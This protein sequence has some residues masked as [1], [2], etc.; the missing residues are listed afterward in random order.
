MVSITVFTTP[1]V[2]YIPHDELILNPSDPT[3]QVILDV[4]L[5]GRHYQIFLGGVLS[6]IGGTS[7]STRHSQYLLALVALLNDARVAKGLPTLGLLNPL[8]YSNGMASTFNGITSGS[9]PGCGTP[10]F[11]A[12]EGW[13]PGRSCFVQ[14]KFTVTEIALHNAQ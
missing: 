12:T 11:N 14:Y 2:A 8:L 1:P 9:N 7:A 10:G 6:Q 5:Q 13:D 4:S 3:L